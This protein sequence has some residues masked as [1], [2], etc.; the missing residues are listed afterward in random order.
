MANRHVVA[1]VRGAL[2][3]GWTRDREYPRSALM[4][5]KNE[6]GHRAVALEPGRAGY[7]HATL[8]ILQRINGELAVI[9]D[10]KIGAWQQ[11]IDILATYGIVNRRHTFTYRQ[12]LVNGRRE[13]RRD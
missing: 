7:P 11:A 3:D 13:A 9:A 12:G 1:A 4:V 2:A 5:W 10:C 6:R 8:R